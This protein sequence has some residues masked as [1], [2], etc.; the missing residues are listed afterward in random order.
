MFEAFLITLIVVGYFV[1]FCFLL[2]RS[3]YDNKAAMAGF[4]FWC[5]MAVFFL[6]C[7]GMEESKR[8]PCIEWQTQMM[9]NAATKMMQPAK[10]CVQR[11]EWEE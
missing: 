5:A 2:T 1:V 11:G 9:Y 7:A 8:G 10:F 6:I 4:V 3:L